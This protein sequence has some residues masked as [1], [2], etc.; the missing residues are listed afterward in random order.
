MPIV[1]GKA[2][3]RQISTTISTKWRSFLVIVV[4]DNVSVIWISRASALWI[5]D[6]ARPVA[7]S[8]PRPFCAMGNSLEACHTGK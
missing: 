2:S 6:D 8:A 5:I 7:L 3:K 1:L 4:P